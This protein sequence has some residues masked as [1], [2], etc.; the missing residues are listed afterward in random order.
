MFAEYAYLCNNNANQV[1]KN[2]LVLF[3][4]ARLVTQYTSARLEFPVVGKNIIKRANSLHYDILF[5][6]LLQFGLYFN[7]VYKSLKFRFRSRKHF[8]G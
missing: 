6:L 5:P 1:W 3:D 8:V 2:P 7:I 4:K